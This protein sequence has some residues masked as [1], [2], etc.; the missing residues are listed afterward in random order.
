VTPLL[1]VEQSLAVAAGV[2]AAD[3]VIVLPRARRRRRWRRVW[4]PLCPDALIEALAAAPLDAIVLAR[5]A[6]VDEGAALLAPLARLRGLGVV[7][8]PDSADAATWTVALAVA[9]ADAGERDLVRGLE[10]AASLPGH[11]ALPRR[12]W[13]QSGVAVPAVRPRVLA[14]WAAR[15]WRPCEWCRAGGGLASGRCGRCGA[16]VRPRARMA[17]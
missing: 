4:A 8:L 9:W 5:D 1:V 11:E 13:G 12:A 17:T 3:P 2:R 7:P 16:G 15:A 14:R 6:P 10:V